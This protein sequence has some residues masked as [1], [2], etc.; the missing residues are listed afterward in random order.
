[1]K[2]T[3][4][5]LVSFVFSLSL[6]AQGVPTSSYS[7]E[8][9]CIAETPREKLFD[10]SASAVGPQEAFEFSIRRVGEVYSM[11]A[12]IWLKDEVAYGDHSNIAFLLDNGELF[13]LESLYEGYSGQAFLKGNYFDTCFA[14]PEDI[15]QKLRE[16][17]VTAMRINY[18][19]G[20][21]DAEISP[22]KQDA[23]SR[24]IR[25]LDAKS[26]K[27]E[28]PASYVTL[29]HDKSDF[30]HPD[31]SVSLGSTGLG[32]DVAAPFGRYL[33]LRTGVTWMPSITRH[34]TYTIDMGDYGISEEETDE[35]TLFDKAT[36]LFKEVTGYELSNTVGMTARTNFL[37]Y[38]LL[39]DVFPFADGRFH[40]TTGF[41]LGNS[42]IARVTSDAESAPLFLALGAYNNLLCN[43]VDG[44]PLATVGN[45]SVYLPKELEDKLWYHADDVAR[46]KTPGYD[47]LLPSEQD[48][49]MKYYGR[50][51]AHIGN[52]VSDGQPYYMVPDEKG[53]IRMDV[54]V[55][56]FKP[57]LG[58]GYGGS[59]SKRNDTYRLSFDCG[60]MFW[61]G[62]PRVIMHDGT[63]IVNDVT[64]V[65]GK[66]GE[67]CDFARRFQMFPV[68]NLRLSRRLF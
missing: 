47:D 24:M 39:L 55:N 28:I 14:L 41:Y 34:L 54:L 29:A 13:E 36:D 5:A 56:R 52:R 9:A 26:V 46:A 12:I 18:E 40:V 25:S 19:G 38:H 10:Q 21:F 65:D 30:F 42:R 4:V 1:M 17:K 8:E 58:V 53:M 32:L 22:A 35:P 33:Q 27:A 48:E 50:L 45:L 68:I 62:S 15:V 31:L 11:P 7:A 49:L 66:I 43:V 51:S 16:H 44:N 67:Y 64:G 59:L 60:A 3:I 37:N 6:A 63:D 23:V 20:F 57:Y 61:G 2:K